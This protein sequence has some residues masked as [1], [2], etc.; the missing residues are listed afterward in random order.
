MSSL[1]IVLIKILLILNKIKIIIK[2]N[3]KRLEKIQLHYYFL[4]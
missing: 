3:K 4:L 2:E 1:L